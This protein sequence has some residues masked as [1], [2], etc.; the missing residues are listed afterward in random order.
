MQQ[1]CWLTIIYTAIWHDGIMMLQ[2]YYHVREPTK[3]DKKELSTAL[4]EVSFFTIVIAVGRKSYA[5]CDPKNLLFIVSFHERQAKT[6]HRNGSWTL[7]AFYLA[8]TKVCTVVNGGSVGVPEATERWIWLKLSM[9]LSTAKVTFLIE[10][11]G[12]MLWCCEPCYLKTWR[13]QRSLLRIIGDTVVNRKL[14]LKH[15]KL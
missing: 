2:Y 15:A 7:K 8:H 13:I 10:L 5:S 4:Y 14:H 1:Q 11:N 9:K 12:K 3:T 6:I